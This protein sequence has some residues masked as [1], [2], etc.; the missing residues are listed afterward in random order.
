MAELASVQALVGELLSGGRAKA[1]NVVKLLS[2]L[3][4]TK[5]EPSAKAAIQGLKQFFVAAG[6]DG[7]LAEGLPGAPVRPAKRQKLAGG[8][9]GAA[10]AAAEDD[11]ES[12]YRQWLGRQ[13]AG[14]TEALLAIATSGASASAASNP[15]AA[16]PAAAAAAEP[17]AGAA[18]PACAASASGGLAVVA[19]AAVMEL[20]RV[21]AGPGV[22]SARLFGRLLGGMLAGRGVRGEVFSL[23]F[24]KHMGH[25]DVRFYTLAT[26]RALAARHAAAPEGAG[27]EEEEEDEGPSSSAA[28]AA[29][30]GALGSG[31]SDPS[32]A[33]AAR[34][35]SLPDLARNCLDCL[36][37]CP[38]ALDPDPRDWSSWCGATEFNMVSATADKN[39]SA[40]VRRRRKE[41]EAAAAAAG[42][43]AA[44][45]AA[46]AQPRAQWANAKT[47]KRLY[48]E[49][50]MALLR[51]PLPSDALRRA[52]VALPER[53]LPHL[54]APQ[55]LADLLTHCVG[56]GG[57]TGMLALNGL[58]I[59]VTRHGLEYPQFYERLYSL[60]VP[61]AFSARSRSQFFRLADLF[62]S[63]TLVPAYTVAAF[64]KRFAR[65]ALTASPPGA[66]LAIAFVHNLIRRHPALG[67]MLHNPPGP[68]EA[69]A[70][71]EGAGSGKWAR[72][73][74]DVYDE[75][76]P[77]P[78][79]SRA[80][81]SSLWELEA[82]RSHYC[83]QVSAF[84]CVLDKDLTDRTKTAEVA[85]D[86]LL[87]AG[88][89]AA[90]GAAAGGGSYAA[91][92]RGEL[93]RRLK[94]APVAFYPAGKAPV[95]L[96]GPGGAD[97]ED[98]GGWA[99]QPEG[100]GAGGA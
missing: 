4:S 65:L 32:A 98:W 73:G 63:S 20:V 15:A 27:R 95:A 58:F 82:L 84:V 100:A 56:R 51:L 75:A 45:A 47:Q 24:A 62:L 78:A 41:A 70:G 86:A 9:E 59:L 88:A 40:R 33:A 2:I 93:G 72:R 97:A 34:P 94:A 1:N 26:V 18:G 77:D 19:A 48:G 71:A 60:L 31:A 52:L 96:F 3:N 91:L 44:A 36:L 81:E 50:W 68:G 66:M 42:G 90:G 5:H 43:Q 13:Y 79:R 54:A 57:L 39:E 6:S 7:Q 49:A 89:G 22:F 67:V 14:L 38:D 25:A 74:V 30:A 16:T 11:P 10:A 46:P 80:V 21:E 69:E 8:A 28:A 92:V 76:Q 83:P 64:A 29:V 53:L 99:L 12:R 55:H 17:G 23:L 37:R 85:L 87:G 61:E 35:A